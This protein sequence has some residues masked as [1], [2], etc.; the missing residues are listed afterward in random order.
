MKNCVL[1]DAGLLAQELGTE[2]VKE[3]ENSH[4]GHYVSAHRR[5]QNELLSLKNFLN[6]SWFVVSVTALSKIKWNL[7]CSGIH[8]VIEWFLNGIYF[9]TKVEK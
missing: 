5:H 6:F 2:K 1:H 8:K 7:E 4:V 9:L 3:N